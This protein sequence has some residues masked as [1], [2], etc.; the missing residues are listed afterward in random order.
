MKLTFLFAAIACIAYGQRTVPD[1]LSLWTRPVSR[2]PKFD[3]RRMRRG[4]GGVA[5]P[6]VKPAGEFERAR[7]RQAVAASDGVDTRMLRATQYDPEATSRWPAWWRRA[8]A[9]DLPELSPAPLT[10]AGDRAIAEVVVPRSDSEASNQEAEL[11]ALWQRGYRDTLVVW[12]GE[13]VPRVARLVRRVR[14]LGWR[15]LFAHGPH[16]LPSSTPYINAEK[17][18]RV[19]DACLP[20]CEAVLVHWRK[21]SGPHWSSPS[22]YADVI[23]A[24]ARDANPRIAVI[25][26][27]YVKQPG[28][29]LVT[30]VPGCASAV[31]V[32]NASSAGAR[33]NGVRELVRKATDAPLGVLIIGPRPY[34][35]TLGAGRVDMTDAEIRD[36]CH[37]RENDFLAADWSFTITLA[38]DGYGE[39]VFEG[40]RQSDALTK[41]QWRNVR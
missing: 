15:V 6:V 39:R 26:E 11:A 8:L 31:L 3:G 23:A 40:R 9:A 5:V 13:P 20:Y 19:F 35:R 16:E 25:G 1:T 33:V 37:N 7:L 18:R 17:L 30:A 21:T 24:L 38:G 4:A 28:Y 36:W 10:I 22:R 32:V 41:S 2:A 14:A 27:V 12:R 29:E 34:Y